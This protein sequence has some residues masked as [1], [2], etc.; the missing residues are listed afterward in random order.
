MLPQL[1]QDLLSNEWVCVAPKRIKR[2]HSLVKVVIKK[3]VSPK[4]CPFENLVKSGNKILVENEEIKIIENKFPA[5]SLK[6]YCPLEEK[7]GLHKVIDALGHHEI[8]ITKYHFKNLSQLSLKQITFVLDSF[9]KRILGFKKDLCVKYVSVFQNWG[10]KAGASVY[11]PHFQIIAI[12]II[13]PLVLNLI[14]IAKKYFIKNKKCIHCY[15]IDWEKKKKQRIFYENKGAIVIVPFAS[16]EPF[17]FRVFPKKHISSFEE[18][19]KKDLNYI[20][21]ALQHSLKKLSKNLKDPDY[22]LHIRTTP[23]KKNGKYDYYHWYIEITTKLTIAAGFEENSGI[24]INP[25]DPI[26]TTK[27]L[28]K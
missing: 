3:K 19:T 16:K 9:K 27:I 8:L 10:E 25:I 5:F 12:P 13:P 24:E 17:Q 14:N 2:N 6:N 1:R 7:K 11:H 21:E 22:N 15:L 18:T 26:E 23:L 28:R 4:E 20:A